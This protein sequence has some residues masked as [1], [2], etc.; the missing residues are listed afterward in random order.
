MLVITELQAEGGKHG[1]QSV[2]Q[3]AFFVLLFQ[4]LYSLCPAHIAGVAAG[5]CK[6]GELQRVGTVRGRLAG[7]DQFVEE[8]LPPL[9]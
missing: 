5:E 2:G 9:G 3:Y 4:F 8:Y 1:L 7:G 6:G